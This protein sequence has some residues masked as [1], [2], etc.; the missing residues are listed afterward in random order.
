MGLFFRGGWRIALLTT[1]LLSVIQPSFGESTPTP[2]TQ[3]ALTQEAQV[4]FLESPAEA[5]FARY[6][7]IESAQTSIQTQYFSVYDDDFG[8]AFQALLMEKARAGV[9][10]ELM[11]DARGTY[12][13]WRNPTYDAL[14]EA[15]VDVRLY[16]P[17][18][19]DGNFALIASNHDKIL[20][21]DET[22]LI[23]GG[24]NIGAP[25]FV[26]HQETADLFAFADFDVWI[27]FKEK[28]SSSLESFYSEFNSK[29]VRKL[30]NNSSP[31]ETLAAQKLLERQL[32]AMR[33]LM[34]QRNLSE[35]EIQEFP[36]LQRYASIA[37]FR[38]FK[39]FSSSKHYP[40]RV[41]DNQS[42]LQA[43][44][45]LT[46]ETYRLIATAKTQ[47]TIQNPYLVLTRR[48]RKALS[49]AGQRGVKITFLITSH[50]STDSLWTQAI[51][52]KEWPDILKSIPGAEMYASKGPETLHAKLMVVDHE[53][54]IV[55]TY[56]MD[57]L[58]EKRNSE[59][60][61]LIDSPEVAQ[62]VQ[63][64]TAWNIANNSV[65]YDPITGRGPELIDDPSGEM[66]ILKRRYFWA[67]LIRPFL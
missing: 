35:A 8:R 48:A 26:D 36:L 2:P 17:I 6:Q 5:W 31:Q 58:S 1:G 29:H 55:G 46:E 18:L 10:V 63:A 34:R 11:V 30:K 50:A 22:Q 59:I 9:K 13:I 51:L 41:L 15:G 57:P 32:S 23:T 12:R 54:A 47:I 67:Q 25:Y 3:G 4:Q 62:K 39:S 56:N 7:L 40:V 49:E 27:R 33:A 37:N 60:A 61:V 44:A 65:Q 64:H 66:K 14:I 24:R 28:S 43:K 45:E 53:K 21:V 42:R 16:N 52:Q 20:L 38:H 19:G